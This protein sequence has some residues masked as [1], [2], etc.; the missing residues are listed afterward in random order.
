MAPWKLCL[1]S[2]LF[3]FDDVF[4]AEKYSFVYAYVSFDRSFYLSFSYAC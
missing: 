4:D 2:C 3:A 1:A